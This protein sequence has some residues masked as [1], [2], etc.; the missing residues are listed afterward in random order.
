MTTEQTCQVYW[1]TQCTVFLTPSTG[2]RGC[3]TFLRV[4]KKLHFL[5]FNFFSDFYFFFVW[6]HCLIIGSLQPVIK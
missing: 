5:V 2:L 6:I 4:L 1:F 3:R